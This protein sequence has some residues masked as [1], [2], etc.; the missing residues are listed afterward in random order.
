MSVACSSFIL[1]PLLIFPFTLQVA[2]VILLPALLIISLG[3]L[4]G[5]C[6]DAASF[7]L[8]IILLPCGSLSI[9]FI[10]DRQYIGRYAGE[11]LVHQIFIRGSGFA[12]RRPTSPGCHEYFP[13]M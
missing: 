5:Y 7:P 8:L 1:L 3:L 4:A 2:M 10:G 11:A 13:G 12:K 9:S 6:P